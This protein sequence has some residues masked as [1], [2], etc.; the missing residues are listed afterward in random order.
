MPKKIF[1]FAAMCLL[2]TG[3]PGWGFDLKPG[4]YEITAKV[5]M[6]GMPGVMPPQTMI[7]CLD[8]QDPVPTSS[9]DAQGCKMIDMDITGN[10]V[11]YTMECNQQGTK[12]QSK[13]K[14]TYSGTSFQGS[15]KTIMGPAAGGLTIKT[16]IKGK[17]IG[18]C[19]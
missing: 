2:L 6:P 4:K 3:L 8:K 13:G 5:E 1:I 14:I 19:N 16:E 7:Q 10:T 15:T 9:A 17:R 11:T 18:S 12:I